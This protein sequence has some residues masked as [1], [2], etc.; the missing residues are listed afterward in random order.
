MHTNSWVFLSL[1]IL[2]I[3]DCEIP[4]FLCIV[5]FAHAAFQKLVNHASPLL[6]N[7]NVPLIP[8]DDTITCY[9]LT[10]LSV[11]HSKQVF[12]SIP[13]HP[14]SFVASVPTFVVGTKFRMSVYLQKQYC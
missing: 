2:W 7:Y 1:L 10:C 5:L 13:Q 3:V 12:F 8:N 11:E 9:Q 14:Q 4:K 6:V